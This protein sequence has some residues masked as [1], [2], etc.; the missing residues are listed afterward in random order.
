M[1]E[2]N[3]FRRKPIHDIFPN[4]QDNNLASPKFALATDSSATL[5]L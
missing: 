1:Q 3:Q 5:K 2:S 4:T